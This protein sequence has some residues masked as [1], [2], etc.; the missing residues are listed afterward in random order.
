DWNAVIT[1][2]EGGFVPACRLLEPFGPVRKT[3][4]FNLLV[5]RATDPFRL[6]AD[7]HGQLAANPAITTWISRFMPI[8]QLFS[9][10][11]A[12]EFELRS[13][14][15]VLQWLPLLESSRFHLRMHRRGFK[16]KLSSAEEERFLDEF[17]L[18]KL[19]EAGRP[20]KVAFDDPDAIIALETIGTQAGLSI[21]NRDELQRFPLL[22]LD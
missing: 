5:M 10:Q 16:G 1:V 18:Q 22:H 15:A 19:A 6:M 21:F 12:A 11:S 14:E 7:L 2:H 9:Y 13:R 3:E 17:L 8:K 4:F 20:G